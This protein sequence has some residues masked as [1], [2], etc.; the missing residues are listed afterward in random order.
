MIDLEQVI[1]QRYPDFTRRHQRIAKIIIKFFA[2]LFYESRFKQFAATYP[3]LQGYDFVDQTLRYFDFSLRTREFE[4]TRIPT[5][6]RVVIVA[7]HPIGSLDGLA[8]VNLVR[9]V[10]A[11]VKVVANELLLAIEPLHSVLLP[12]D[13]MGGNTA[14]QNLRNIREH[15]H[16]EGALI[17][18]PAGEV[19]RLGPQGIRDEKWLSGFVKIAS[20][21]QSPILPIH[22]KGRNSVFFY[23]LSF[24]AKPLSTI[25]LVREMFKQSH[26]TVDVRIGRAVPHEIYSAT[27]FTAKKVASLFR[28]HVYRL[29]K[30]GKPIFRTVETIAPA[31]SAELMRQ[32]LKQ[33]EQLGQTQDGKHIYLTRLDDSPCVIREIG[34][35]RELTFR[36]IGEGSGNPRDLDRYD[37]DYQ[38]LV[39][40]DPED[41]EIVG[42][43]RLG[44]VQKIIE[45]RGLDGLY[46]HS[47]FRF[48]HRMAPYF[49]Q[50]LELGRS[51]VQPKYQTR[52]SLDYLW[53]GIGAYLKKHPNTRYLFG[54]ASISRHYGSK[55]IAQIALYYQT[56]YNSL[57]LG[58]DPR[59]PFTFDPDVEREMREN[60]LGIDLETDFKALRDNLAEAG[61]PVPVLYKHYAQVAEPEG[62]VFTAFNVDPDFGDCVDGFVLVDLDRLKPRKRQRYLGESIAT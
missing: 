60:V 3:H 62:V 19:S 17:I 27:D 58:V 26:N 44:D 29:G 23:S 33:C 11:D 40:W 50:G 21:T 32:E 12:V 18:F 24:L 7:N 13:N 34:R 46:T 47:L 15:L 48:D 41:R 39:L 22:V 25:W 61:L 42:A 14:R 5:G 30:N 20:S 1:A 9:Q 55:A 38:H 57:D 36:M 8:L 16:Q 56:Y 43:Y 28:K 52:Q 59:N 53:Y 31:E 54:P 4:R 51:F 2:F 45:T 6:G 37:R 35:L 49:A 10:R